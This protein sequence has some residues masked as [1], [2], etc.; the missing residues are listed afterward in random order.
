MPR[1]PTVLVVDDDP[2][3][4]A[5]L[6]DLLRDEGYRVVAVTT[7]ADA[8][9]ALAAF[10]FALV[11]TDA[12]VAVSPQGIDSWAALERIRSAAGATPVVICS[13]HPRRAFAGLAARGFAAHVGKPF[14]IAALCALVRDLVAAGR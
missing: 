1:R 13:A 4:L 6:R 3:V 8:R 14:D 2:L 7:E 9:H 10:R 12:F 11:L 5:L